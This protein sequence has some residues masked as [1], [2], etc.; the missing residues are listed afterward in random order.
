MRK[1]LYTILMLLFGWGV[2]AQNAFYKSNFLYAHTFEEGLNDG[3]Y[4][5]ASTMNCMTFVGMTTP[6]VGGPDPKVPVVDVESTGSI[7]IDDSFDGGVNARCFPQIGES[8]VTPD[9]Y[10]GGNT[11]I[12]NLSFSFMFSANAEPDIQGLYFEAG[13]VNMS[14]LFQMGSVAE[15]RVV[16]HLGNLYGPELFKSEVLSSTDKWNKFYV[17]FDGVNTRIWAGETVTFEIRFWNNG[18]GH[19]FF[20]VDDIA[21]IGNTFC[22]RGNGRIGN[23]IWGDS[24]TNGVVDGT[25]QGVEGVEVRL[26]MD[27]GDGTLNTDPSDGDGLFSVKT[28]DASG[29]YLFENVPEGDFFVVVAPENFDGDSAL[30]G[31]FPTTGPSVSGNSDEDNKDHGVNTTSFKIQGVSS[32][33]V[34]LTENGEP[35]SDGDDDLGNLTLDFGFYDPPT[36]SLGDLIW[37][38]VVED[39]IYNTGDGES[40]LSRVELELYE[41]TD[42]SGDLSTGDELID[43]QITDENGKYLFAG[44]LPEDYILQVPMR[45]FDLSVGPLASLSPSEGATVLDPD[46]NSNNTSDGEQ[47]GLDVI[48][49]PITLTVGGEPTNDGDADNNTNLSLDIGFFACLISP[50]ILGQKSLGGDNIDYPKSVIQ[51]PDGNIVVSG[52]SYSGISGDKTE[53]NQNSDFW[54]VKLDR[55]NQNI[56]WQNTIGGTGSEVGG[57]SGAGGHIINTSDGGFL[58][59]GTSNSGIGGDKTEAGRGSWDFWVIK[60]NASGV[61]QWDKTIGGSSGDFLINAQQTSDGGYILGGFSSS[62]ISGDKTEARVGFLGSDYWVVKLS[63]TGSIQWQKTIGGTDDDQFGEIIQTSDG[64]YLVAG[65]SKSPM[66]GNKTEGTYGNQDYWVV[67]LNSSGAIQ[68]DKTYGGTSTDYLRTIEEYPNGDFLLAGNSNSAIGG[69]KTVSSMSFDFW[70][71]RINNTG[72]IVWQKSYGYTS[73]EN[74]F[75]IQLTKAGKMVVAGS[76]G[77]GVGGDKTEPSQGQGDYW[78]IQIDDDGNVEWDKT[79]GGTAQDDAWSITETNDNNFIVAGLTWSGIGGNKTEANQGNRDYWV[80]EFAPPVDNNCIDAGGLSLGNLI[81]E[82]VDNNGIKAATGEDGIG[83]VTVDLFADNGDGIYNSNDDVRL[84]T[85]VTQNGEYLFENLAPADYFVCVSPDNFQGGVG[86]LQGMTNSTGAVTGNSNLNNRDHGTDTQQ[87]GQ[88]GIVSSVVTLTEMGEP[89]TDGDADNNTNLTIDFGFFTPPP[90]MAIGNLV[91]EDKNNNSFKDAGEPGI[92]NVTVELYEDADGDE[93]LDTAVDTYITDDLTDALGVYGFTNL[94]PGKYFVNIPASNWSGALLGLKNS[95]A[96]G[97]LDFDFDDDDSGV[98]EMHYDEENQGVASSVLTLEYDSEPDVAIDGDGKNGNQTVDFGFYK[99]VKIGNYVW[100]DAN[101][102]GELDA[103]TETPIEGVRLDLFVDSDND[104]LFDKDKDAF[105]WSTFTDGSGNYEFDRLGEDNYFV[106]VSPRNFEKDAPLEEMMT[107]IISVNGDSDLNE[108]NHGKDYTK[109][110]IEGVRS[111]IVTILHNTEPAAGADGDDATGNQ[112]VD[113]GFTTSK[114]CGKAWHDVNEDGI[115][116]TGD[117]LLEGVVVY[118]LDATTEEVLDMRVTGTDG[119]Y[120]F[121]V[122]TGS[123]IIYFDES[124]NTLGTTFATATAINK[125]GATLTDLNDSDVD[126]YTR[127]TIPLSFDTGDSDCDIDA[128]FSVR[129]FPVEMLSFIVFEQKCDAILQWVTATEENNSHFM[130]EKSLDGRN[131]ETIG[132]VEGHGTTAQRQSYSFTDT[133]LDAERIYYRLKQVDF[134]GTYAYTDIVVLK[135]DRRSACLNKLGAALVM[136]NPN[137][138]RFSFLIELE[139]EIGNTTFIL[140]DGLGRRVLVDQAELAV[141]KNIIEF[142]ISNY[143]PGTYTLTANTGNGDY[144]TIRVVFARD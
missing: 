64:G 95:T 79:I 104:G 10:N 25:E 63:S 102:D 47:Q 30:E 128:G 100:E 75:D 22:D 126:S 26:Y 33:I 108:Q 71:L 106:R 111:T 112:T 48:T 127:K 88:F 144:K 121:P 101:N 34:T 52:T 27:D 5:N 84:Q 96:F 125:S 119:T 98:E 116:N 120:T 31:F 82:D 15:Y 56:L 107:S 49:M 118:L 28:T 87:A 6:S 65:H 131:F 123:Y 2:S 3:L 62:G 92:Q 141:G 143:T 135:L 1:V 16:A 70:I 99:E 35:T 69:N 44:L 91:F 77:S 41:D 21:L 129:E 83:G 93:M 109:Y 61:V 122:P 132:K 133:S 86:A 4:R 24:N 11:I 57:S 76:S 55:T 8:E 43:V 50:R 89:I 130:V 9:I 19:P 134:D 74:P 13:Q 46:N 139:E 20:R 37:L 67:K 113:F 78:I 90:V 66:G 18:E 42:N 14:G 68:W 32:S 51:S 60:L 23:L 38:E 81:W 124:G 7:N 114:I 115:F 72:G 39:G 97:G 12:D 80:V 117:L 36:V 142:D 54:V 58:L 138:G 45:N 17:P 73:V 136:P 110:P 137:L 94:P 105:Y 53:V 140:T 59:A 29:H 40:G 85:A 103:G